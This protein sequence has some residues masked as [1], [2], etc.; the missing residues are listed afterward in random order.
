MELEILNWIQNLRTPILDSFMCFITKSGN[1]GLIWIVLVIVLLTMK[2]TR[3]L[4]ILM[5]IA[6]CFEVAICNGL[7]KNLFQRIRPCDMNSAIS[8][9]ISRPSDYSFPSGHTASSFAVVSLLLFMKYKKLGLVCLVLACLI[10]FSRMYLYVHY[11]SDVLGGILVGILCG[12]CAYRLR[13]TIC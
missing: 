6:L 11:P 13:N 2:K 3:K 7:L 10:V 12:Y 4:G 8:L 1:G 9:L 5:G